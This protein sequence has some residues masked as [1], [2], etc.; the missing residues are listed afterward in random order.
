MK[1]ISPELWAVLSE[2]GS[3]GHSRQ[4]AKPPSDADLESATPETVSFYL[5]YQN[6]LEPLKAMGLEVLSES[7]NVVVGKIAINRLVELSEHPNVVFIEKPEPPTTGLDNSIP[8][9]RANLVWSRSGDTFSGKTGKDVVVGIIDTGIDF[10]HKTFRKADNTT[11]ILH[12]WDQTLT[13]QGGDSVPGPIAHTTLGTVALGYG[14]EYDKNQIKTAL[15]SS[16]PF[17]I[18][19]HKDKDGHG[20][21]VTGIAAGDGSQ[22]DACCGAYTYVGVAPEADIIAVRMR[23]LTAGDATPTGSEMI[24]AIRYILQ[25]AGT[26]P[27]SINLSI[28]RNNG[29]RDVKSKDMVSIDNILAAFPTGLAI[30]IIAGNEGDTKRHATGTV[31]SGGGVDVK[32]KVAAGSSAVSVGVHYTGTNLKAA[33]KPPGGALSAFVTDSNTQTFNSI[34]N[35][36]SVAINNG[37]GNIWIN[38]APPQK[39]SNL[40]GDWV[41]RLEDTAATATPFHVWSSA[42][43]GPTFT[44]GGGITV[45]ESTSVSPYATSDNAII[46]GAYA[47]EGA[48]SGE[49][50]GFSSRGPLLVFP[51]GDA[52]NLRPHLS[53]PGVAITSALTGAEGGCCC[54]C[55]Y[56]FYVNMQGTSQAAPHVTGAVALMLQK[57]PKLSFTQI[58]DILRNT[59]RPVA[60]QVLPN[61]DWGSGKLDVKAA[62]DAVPDPP[63]APRTPAAPPAEPVAVR[64][65]APPAE[66]ME[67]RNEFFSVPK[68][69]FYQELV[70]RHFLEVRTLINTNKRVATVWHRNGGPRLIRTGIQASF[71][72]EQPLPVEFDGVRL[73]D[74]VIHIIEILKKYG[75]ESLAQDIE[76]H[77][78]EWID[79]LTEGFS[80]RQLLDFFKQQEAA[81]AFTFS[82]SHAS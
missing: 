62:F 44:A 24:D 29:R 81:P 61:N 10:T 32:L 11:R 16:N 13:A 18:V 6:S 68:A 3:S 5:Q 55:C 20:S 48:K 71:Q 14:V 50:A 15:E 80:P 45:P 63:G 58:R 26:S 19:R 38:F 78:K 7:G 4:T 66:W 35:G 77:V 46:V 59:A 27:V 76:N 60:G 49:L 41:L 25:R 79:V 40:G 51:P 75:S 43:T 23:G 30:V 17:S 69:K 33:I 39:G 36:G 73:S 57:N 34:N 67:M 53:A 42:K 28:Y 9:I 72:P 52:R 70:M 47:T 56:D 37:G 64:F 1:K 82:P 21:H 8:D 22:S 2:K 12:I 65:N 74:R 54:D 31:S